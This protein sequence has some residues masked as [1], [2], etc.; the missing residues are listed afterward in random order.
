MLRAGAMLDD[1]GV[2][3]STR[4]PVAFGTELGFGT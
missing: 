1:T 3:I 4:M 2:A